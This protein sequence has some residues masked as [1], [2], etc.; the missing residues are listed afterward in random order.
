MLNQN[1]RS[2][3]INLGKPIQ[4]LFPR[5][6]LTHHS[7]KEV[8]TPNGRYYETP[9]GCFPSV[10]NVLSSKENKSLDEW[11][12]RVGEEEAN[13][14]SKEATNRGSA[15][16][17]LFENYLKGN[18]IRFKHPT[19]KD[20]FLQAKPLLD[21]I[22]LVY[23]NEIPLYSKVIKVAGR[24]DCVAVID[25]EIQIIDFKTS[26]NFKESEQIESYK[27]QCS[28]YAFMLEE[29]YGIKTNRF[30]IIISNLYEND[31][32][33]FVDDPKKYIK[34]FWELRK[35]WNNTILVNS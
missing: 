18:E 31:C 25:G 17:D 13:R 16:H 22:E 24:C 21:K 30:S 5:R 11:R 2:Q 15:I 7:I 28:A 33:L 9:F 23:A 4:K 29:I 3:N 34:S 32:S 19:L 26:K 1:I 12:E 27:M 10:T 20:H 35:Q 14:V 6:E 8:S